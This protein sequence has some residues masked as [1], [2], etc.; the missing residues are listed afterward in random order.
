MQEVVH[1]HKY[2]LTIYANEVVD[3]RFIYPMDNRSHSRTEL[4]YETGNKLVLKKGEMKD[5]PVSVNG[6]Q[7]NFVTISMC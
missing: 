6:S 5:K 4:P 3:F 1:L 2:R 7:P